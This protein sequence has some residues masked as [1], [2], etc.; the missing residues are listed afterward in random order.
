MIKQE[1]ILNNININNSYLISG[2]SGCGKTTLGF[3]IIKNL[4]EQIN[5]DNAY[6]FPENYPDF[7]YLKGGK[8][9]DIR[10]L[11]IKLNQ[12]PFFNKHFV[13]IDNL[14]ELSVEGQ[15]LLLKTLEES[16]V[17][18][19]LISNDNTKVLKTIFSRT[20]KI[21]PILLEYDEIKR[22]IRE[23]YKDSQ[24]FNLEYFD[25]VTELSGR[26]LGK[27]KKYIDNELIKEFI[28]DLTNISDKNFFILSAKYKEFK[29]LKDEFFY[30]IETHIR[31]SMV[32][33]KNKSEYFNLTV[34]ISKYKKQLVNNANLQMIYQNIFTELIKLSQ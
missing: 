19:V 2:I 6:T 30:L 33:S 28:N 34:E 9:E 26:S 5:P 3:E 25:K 8:T 10:S 23:D 18:F 13:L 32:N 11:L 14:N 27:A 7:H 17:F 15:N 16:D 29:E 12:K 20:Y 4:I 1:K 31:N 22:I 24:N 21:S